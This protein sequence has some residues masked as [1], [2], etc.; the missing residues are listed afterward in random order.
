MN[1]SVKFPCP[2]NPE[3]TT[4][5]IYS[6]HERYKEIKDAFASA[7]YA[8]IISEQ[9]QIIID[10]LVIEKEWFT[11]EHLLIIQAHELGHFTLDH[12]Q[13]FTP[14]KEREADE[15]GLEILKEHNYLE[16]HRIFQEE[17]IERWKA[18]PTIT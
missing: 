6:T 17:C 16:A 7:G 9:K 14:D 18:T 1:S 15:K 3:F 8:F 2:L 5:I 4:T 13:P 11:K 10:G 12:Q